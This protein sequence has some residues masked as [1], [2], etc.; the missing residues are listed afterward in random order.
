MLISQRG[1][2]EVD[3]N[4]V[5]AVPVPE[6][7]ESWR[8]ISNAVLI[9]EVKNQAGI[10]LLGYRLMSEDYCLARGGDQM[11]GVI[12][13]GYD[14]AGPYEPIGLSIG[15]RNSYNRTLSAGIALGAKVTVCSNLMFVGDVITFR[16]HTKFAGMDLT[17]VVAKTLLQADSVY[18]EIEKFRARLRRRNVMD[19]HA[20]ASLGKAYGFGILTES[21]MPIA[22]REWLEPSF[23]EFRD[24]GKTAWRL[25]NA[26]TFALKSAPI[27]NRM[28]RL[29]KLHEMFGG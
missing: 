25:Y 13:Y 6:R 4:T 23:D 16:R 10:H 5:V 27:P 20:F 26:M 7:T 9:Q 19:V 18:A 24:G 3:Y 2:T 15:I 12:T 29:A 28:E 14:E 8:P 11:F 17:D 21:Q 1:S 22:K